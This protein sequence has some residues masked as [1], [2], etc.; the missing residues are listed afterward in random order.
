MLHEDH[1]YRG[2][3]IGAPAALYIGASSLVNEILMIGGKGQHVLKHH[4]MDI[5]TV[6]FV[7]DL[8]AATQDAPPTFLIYQQEAIDVTSLSDCRQRLCHS[9]V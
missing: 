4:A 5:P 3:S 9:L 7:F 2:G 6:T 8:S 1:H